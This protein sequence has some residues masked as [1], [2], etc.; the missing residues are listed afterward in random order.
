MIRKNLKKKEVSTLS[1]S[2]E[3]EQLVS[4]KIIQ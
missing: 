2:Y 3:K 4:Q 1:S